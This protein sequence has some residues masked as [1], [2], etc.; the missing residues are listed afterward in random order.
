MP[1][2]TKN[3]VAW[4]RYFNETGNLEE[5]D[6]QGY[7]YVTASDL[8]N[9]AE[10]E[11]R[12][13]AKLDTSSTRPKVFRDNDLTIFPVRN[14]E[15]IVF[16]DPEKKSYFDY[17]SELDDLEIQ[18]YNANVNLNSFATYPQDE[19]LSESQA[20]DFS[21]IASLF[22]KFVN[23]TNLNL[24]VRGRLFS[25]NFS[26]MLPEV[27]NQVNVSGVQIE[28]DSGYESKKGIYIVEAKVG[29]R[30]DFHIRQ[31]YYPYLEWSKKSDKSVVPIFFTFTNGK[32]YLTRFSFSEDF[33]SLSIVKS[34]C[35]TINE[36]PK[37]EVSISDMTE[38]D[39][40]RREPSSDVPYP[41][42]N[43][44]DKIVDLVQFI[45]EGL[46]DKNDISKF[47]DFDERQA[48]YYSNAGVY[49]GFIKKVEESG[50]FVLTAKGR[51]FVSLK[52]RS[53]RVHY[54]VEE[55]TNKKSFNEA[56]KIFSRRNFNIDNVKNEEI[57]AIIR[58]YR[59]ELGKNTSKRR[60]STVKAWFKWILNNCDVR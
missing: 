43:D 16:R 23:D 30:E 6:R 56:L 31:L 46:K 18:E 11:P 2:K 5:I 9:I 32:Y 4:E 21:F 27:E 47:F 14:G 17:G 13:M 51:E 35:F 25:D 19:S 24:T 36:A 22:S 15:Y 8:K 60:A 59:N 34:Q 55:M 42:A 28:V 48:D 45:N 3:D 57:A 41:Q 10:R 50:S 54:L 49:L 53:K 58:D 52:A 38:V 40:E 26:F 29:K 1:R 37:P 20:I 33:G 12:L 7:F 39:K 44:L